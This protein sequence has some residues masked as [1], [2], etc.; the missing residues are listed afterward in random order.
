LPYRRDHDRHHGRARHQ[1]F[2]VVFGPEFGDVGFV[3]GQ[4]DAQVD[5]AVKGQFLGQL[6]IDQLVDRDRLALHEGVLDEFGRGHADFLGEFGDGQRFGQDH[7]TLDDGGLFFLGSLSLGCL[8][9]LTLSGRRN[10]SASP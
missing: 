4:F 8:G 10:S 9:W 3:A 2:G 1:V 5:V 7:R 6:E